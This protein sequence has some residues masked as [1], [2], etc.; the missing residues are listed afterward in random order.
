MDSKVIDP[1]HPIS[2]KD[3]V[4]NTDMWQLIVNK[5]KNKVCPHLIICGPAGI[6]KSTFIRTCL[7]NAGYNVLT[8][9]CIADS[10]FDTI[11]SIPT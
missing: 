3:I 2:T 7:T 1:N 5:I 11:A 9:N 8:H 6:G 10:G 4:G